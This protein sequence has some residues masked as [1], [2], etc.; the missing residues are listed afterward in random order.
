M[1]HQ[2]SFL[3]FPDVLRRSALPKSSMYRRMSAGLFP[4]PFAISERGRAWREDVI[5]GYNRLIACGATDEAIRTYCASVAPP[6]SKKPMK[7]I[8]AVV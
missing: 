5:D 8:R 1:S 4:R 3:R 7:R 6:T 2:I